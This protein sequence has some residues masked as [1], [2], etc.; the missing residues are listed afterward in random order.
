MKMTKISGY[1]FAMMALLAVCGGAS[2]AGVACPAAS[3]VKQA[4]TSNAGTQQEETDYVATESG[5]TWKGS[6]SAYDEQNVDLKTLSAGKASTANAKGL[7][8]CDYFNGA[9]ATLRLTMDTS[10]AGAPAK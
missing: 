1:S 7:V 9:T 4:G 6:V 10:N 8:A 3:A 2:A 5:K